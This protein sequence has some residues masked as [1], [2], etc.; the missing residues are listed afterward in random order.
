MATGT[1]PVPPLTHERA[2]VPLSG[3]QGWAERT[4][5][6]M[7]MSAESECGP[8]VEG[9]V[10]RAFGR[11]WRLLALV[12]ARATLHSMDIGLAGSARWSPTPSDSPRPLNPAWIQAAR[13]TSPA[14]FVATLVSDVEP[15]HPWSS[16]RSGTPGVADCAAAGLRKQT[17][18][19]TMGVLGGQAK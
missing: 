14:P 18:R 12:G 16:S 4:R 10:G 7:A 19:K 5:A 9:A 13:S 15:G 8:G 11:W 3:G 2:E 6:S 1:P 17:I